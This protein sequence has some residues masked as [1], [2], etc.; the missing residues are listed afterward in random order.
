MAVPLGAKNKHNHKKQVLS[1]SLLNKFFFNA[2]LAPCQCS[3]APIYISPSN[4]QNCVIISQ[5]FL[6]LPVLFF[7]FTIKSQVTCFIFYSCDVT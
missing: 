5:Y 6:P 3:Y 7:Y 1:Q 2:H 4:S